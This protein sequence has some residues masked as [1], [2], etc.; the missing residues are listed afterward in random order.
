MT[1]VVTL[2]FTEQ[3]NSD[4]ITAVMAG[5]IG[6]Y[7]YSGGFTEPAFSV[8]QNL[9][10]KRTERP[11]VTGLE[12][13]LEP[14][15]KVNRMGY[16]SSYHERQYSR[17]TLKQWDITLR[18]YGDAMFLVDRLDNVECSSIK[19][20]PRYAQIDNLDQV[21]FLLYDLVDKMPCAQ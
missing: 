5:R 21:S 1:Q 19:V 8:E 9:E 13:V 7:S 4:A 16:A 20:M 2:A 11:K 14:N 6:T 12:I 3:Q 10:N 15:V 18:A 17:V